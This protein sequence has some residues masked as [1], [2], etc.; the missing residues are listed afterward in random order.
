MIFPEMFCSIEALGVDVLCPLWGCVLVQRSCK[1][2]SSRFQDF[3]AD[4]V[5]QEMILAKGQS[6]VF[7]ASSATASFLPRCTERRTPDPRWGQCL[8]KAQLLLGFYSSNMRWLKFQVNFGSSGGWGGVWA[9][10]IREA[11]A[12]AVGVLVCLE[13]E[14]G[15][16]TRDSVCVRIVRNA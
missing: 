8:S 3:R 6:Q 14:W 7:L 9:V 11:G 16:E 15:K 1:R 13:S 5:W 4:P 10:Q 12:G 2:R